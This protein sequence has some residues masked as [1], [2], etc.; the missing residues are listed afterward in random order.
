LIYGQ[1]V[2]N[3]FISKTQLKIRRRFVLSYL[4][5]TFAKHAKF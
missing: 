4:R 3:K 2:E 1:R 5:F